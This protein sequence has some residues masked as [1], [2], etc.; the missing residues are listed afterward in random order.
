MG[1]VSIDTTNT[2][3]D[4][5]RSQFSALINKDGKIFKALVANPKGNG[6]LEQIFKD[7]EAARDEWCNNSDF[8]E[9][10][11][12]KLEKTM[13]YFSYLERLHEE[14]DT[15]L[16]RRNELLFY[17]GGDTQ[18]GD[19][20]NIRRM[21]QQ[22][23]ETEYVYIVNNTNPIN[24]NL[25]LDG[26]F[27][28]QTTWVLDGCTY[29]EEARF[30]ERTGVKFCDIGTCKQSANVIPD[31]TYFLHFFLEGNIAVQIKDNN[32][33]Y[34]DS[35]A[36][37]FGNWVT[38]ERNVEFS[39]KKW[40][41]KSIYF[42]TDENVSSVTITFIGLRNHSAFLDY[43]RLFK[44]EAYSSFSLIAVFG[45]IYTE[46]TLGF[47]PGKD[48]PVVRRTYNAFGHYSAGKN[49]TGEIENDFYMN[50]ETPLAPWEN[51]E[52]GVTVDYKRMSYIE[53]SHIF[54]TE[55]SIEMAQSIYTE[56]LEMV[57]AGGITSY[58]EILTRELD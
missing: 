21:F 54:G 24:E 11:G 55:G 49:D 25:L 1:N 18:W 26:D 6:T 29:D 57:G 5:L 31:S 53:H 8:Y 10:S 33:R 35:R 4:F 43:V 20:S 36:G 9:M 16:K 7:I 22:Y 34:W 30:S 42:L 41:A 56:L 51:D 13:A 32:G 2:V 3:G 50:E 14:S 48:D 15:S 58:I 45:G 47:A 39:A 44:K 17:R 37:E 40:D 27:E 12:E 23:F 19:L 38:L 28:L 46:D 52:E